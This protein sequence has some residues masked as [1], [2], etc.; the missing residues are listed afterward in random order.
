MITFF[1][2]SESDCIVNVLQFFIHSFVDG[3]FVWLPCLFKVLFAV[4]IRLGVGLP[5]PCQLRHF[6]LSSLVAVT[7]DISG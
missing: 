4:H 2:M 1:F 3:K 5:D 7:F 6:I